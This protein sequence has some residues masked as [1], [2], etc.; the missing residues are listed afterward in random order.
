MDGVINTR[1]MYKI[2]KEHISQ[3]L[4]KY[5]ARRDKAIEIIANCHSMIKE[6]QDLIV[7]NVD[8]EQAMKDVKRLNN[9]DTK[10]YIDDIKIL[11][12]KSNEDLYDY[13]SSLRGSLL[14]ARQKSL[15]LELYNYAINDLKQA[16]VGYN[17]YKSI[18]NKYNVE[19]VWDIIHG[20]KDFSFGGS[21]GKIDVT[22]KKCNYKETNGWLG[23]R[24]NFKE[25]LKTK[26]LLLTQ[27]KT[28]YKATKDD[29][30]RI[31]SDNGGVKYIVYHND[32]YF[33]YITWHC[34]RTGIKGKQSYV[35]AP[36]R[37]SPVM[38][39]E[40]DN[41]VTMDTLK[42]MVERGVTKYEDIKYMNL[43]FIKKLFLAKDLY[44]NHKLLF[45][46]DIIR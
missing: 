10:K 41:Q 2:Y 26:N 37:Q 38:V 45:V 8:L 15:M 7:T 39:D 29:Y 18:I 1:G 27:G 35:F 33:P 46:N 22:Y 20:K 36:T 21:V 44:P 30:G 9:V 14:N 4:D 5:T 40:N 31:I 19:A 12:N 32:D 3:Q 23:R 43:G 28:L 34:R 6:L 11:S 42:G 25:T 17:I 13:H 16:D 24:V